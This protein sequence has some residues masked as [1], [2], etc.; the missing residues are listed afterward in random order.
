MK[1]TISPVVQ[2]NSATAEES[3]AAGEE[4]FNQAENTRQL[5]SH[6]QVRKIYAS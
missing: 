1:D 3:A 2:T 5:G 4:L 6:F